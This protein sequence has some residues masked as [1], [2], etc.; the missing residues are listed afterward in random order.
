VSKPSAIALRQDTDGQI[1]VA[2]EIHARFHAMK[3]YGKE[4]E[5]LESITTTMLKDLADFP[6]DQIALA[7]KIHAQRS[8]EFPTT[9]DIVG[10]IK[11][12]GKPPLKES[13]IIAIRKKDGEH[14]TRE[15]WG[16]LTEWDAQQNESFPEFADDTAKHDALLA[17]NISLRRQLASAKDEISRLS[18]LLTEARVANGIEQ[19]KPDMQTKI[20][21]TAKHMRETGAPQENIDEFLLSNGVTP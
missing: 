17:D 21:R 5:S 11:R 19:P 6:K 13:D 12:K 18:N 3:T 7:F 2:K 4:P 9:A 14:R 10:L 8:V 20:D 15:D 16:M 1:T